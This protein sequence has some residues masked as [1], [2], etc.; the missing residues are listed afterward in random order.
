MQIA[1]C[2]RQQATNLR[3]VGSRCARCG[4]LLFPERVRCSSCGSTELER[5]RFCG[6]GRVCSFTNVHEAPGGFAEQVPYLAALVRLEEGPLVAAMI[7]DA[8]A[9]EVSEGMPVEMVTRRIRAEGETGPIVYAYKFA[10]PMSADR[11]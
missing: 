2:W 9:S 1:R 3:L 11:D 6:R 10:P 5:L 8:D 7:T 4:E